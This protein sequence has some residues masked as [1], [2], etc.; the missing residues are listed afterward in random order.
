MTS[1]FG[2]TFPADDLAKLCRGK[3]ID[4]I[5]M[6]SDCLRLYVLSLGLNPWVGGDWRF[7]GIQC[8]AVDHGE[9]PHS[10]DYS[11]DW[12][13]RHPVREPSIEFRVVENVGVC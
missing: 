6:S 5:E 8:V 2:S 11:S 3:S 1:S 7:D 10:W 13:K 12:Q 9:Y 4:R